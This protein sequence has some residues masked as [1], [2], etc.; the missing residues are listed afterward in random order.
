MVDS[1]SSFEPLCFPKEILSCRTW[2]RFV[3]LPKSLG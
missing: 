1:G 2:Q 3:M